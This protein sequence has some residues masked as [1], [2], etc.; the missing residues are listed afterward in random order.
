MVEKWSA[1]IFIEKNK[2]K[3]KVKKT[4]KYIRN[5]KNNKIQKNKNGI[6]NFLWFTIVEYGKTNTHTKNFMG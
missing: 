2:Y 6:H 4:K 1:T 3:T 5:S